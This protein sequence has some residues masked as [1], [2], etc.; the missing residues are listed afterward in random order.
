VSVALAVEW[1]W[2]WRFVVLS[3]SRY[4]NGD[5]GIV[6]ICIVYVEIMVVVVPFHGGAAWF[7]VG[8]R[9]GSHCWRL[10]MKEDKEKQI[11]TMVEIFNSHVL[12]DFVG[13]QTELVQKKCVSYHASFLHLQRIKHQKRLK[14]RQWMGHMYV[15]FSH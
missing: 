7:V 1:W 6:V 10:W 14:R 5:D 15:F 13:L 3:S 11:N 8:S 2:W 4:R 9:H 12:S